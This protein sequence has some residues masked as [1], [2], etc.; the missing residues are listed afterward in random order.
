MNIPCNTRNFIYKAHCLKCQKDYI[1]CSAR[2]A[3]E[4]MKE[5]ESSVRLRHQNERTALGQHKDE[6]HALE[7]DDINEIYEFEVL[8]KAKD[9]LGAFLK[10][11]IL[12]KKHRPAI[13]GQITNG[14]VL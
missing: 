11:A 10:E 3:S 7:K 5:Y 6:K 2:P 14:F 4:R 9:P 13:N 8:A 1:G 12:I